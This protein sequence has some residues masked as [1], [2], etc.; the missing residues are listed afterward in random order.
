[1]RILIASS[2][3]SID[4]PRVFQKE[5][6]SLAKR[7]DVHLVGVG[8]PAAD[9]LKAKGVELHPFERKGGRLRGTLRAYR[10]I[11]KCYREVRPDIFHFHDPELV[12]MGLWLSVFA[13][14]KVVYDVHE[15]VLKTLAK[16]SWV[17]QLLKRPLAWLFG[18]L[19]MVAV[20]RFE[21]AVVAEPYAMQRFS[22]PNAVLVRNYFPLF[23]DRP[24]EVFDGS[25]PLRL[26]YVGSLTKMRG[27]SS[28]VEALDLMK[29]PAQLSL[30]GRFHSESFR[31]EVLSGRTNVEYLGWVSLDK[32]FNYLLDA[33]I[34]MNCVLPAPSH[35][36]MLGTKVFDYMAARLPIIASNFS[37]WPEIIEK[38]GC[39]VCVDPSD[40]RAIAAAV[41]ELAGAPER[42]ASMGEAGRRLFEE[43]YNWPLEEAKL[44]EAYSR[45]GL[46]GGGN[47]KAEGGN[48]V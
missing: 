6:V 43:K 46:A 42:L 28:L 38:A 15:D 10:R 41:D 37:V 40:P 34:G 44:L 27:V 4:D 36:E 25:R 22:G 7:Y 16:K 2:L 33:D 29:T 13:G 45:L 30:V 11:Y 12:P 20:R 5:A 39:G 35:H 21:L 24:R 26:I 8:E 14:C 31:D 18:R 9:L 48:K 17:P 47:P 23:R 19:E 32:V 3:H 1:M